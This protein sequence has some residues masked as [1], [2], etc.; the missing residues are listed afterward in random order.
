MLNGNRYSKH[1]ISSYKIIK[2]TK[3]SYYNQ[4]TYVIVDLVNNLQMIIDPGYNFENI[5][6]III[7]NYFPL[8]YI[9]LTHGHFDH[10]IAAADLCSYYN[11][12][13]YIHKKDLKL[14]KQCSNYA[15]IFEKRKISAPKRIIAFNDTPSLIT[16]SFS[17][18]HIPGHTEGSVCYIFQ[19]FVFT[20][21][22][23]LF[24]E[25]GR[26]D[27]PDGNKEELSDSLKKIFETLSDDVV[28]FPGH[29]NLFT[30]AEAKS[31]LRL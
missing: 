17:I 4:N 21:D 30:L 3:N 19:K 24:N 5:K 27:L 15:Y 12:S 29:G 13:C 8:Q 1:N 7:Q 20:G 26:T 16:S 2:L 18:L 9:F 23:L 10:A 28:V 14:L 6:E 11:I 22:T 25:T 31:W